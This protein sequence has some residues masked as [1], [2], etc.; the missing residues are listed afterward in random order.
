MSGLVLLRHDDARSLLAAAGEFL[1]AREAEHNLI[2]GLCSRLELDPAPYGETPYLV[3]VGRGG[4]IAAVALRTPPYKLVL[5]RIDRPA[6]VDLV[7]DDAAAVFPALPGVSGPSAAT[8]RFADCWRRLR[9]VEPRPG[10]AQRILRAERVV[11]PRPVPGVMRRAEAGDRPLL[12]DWL[13]A[14]TT[15]A[16]PGAPAGDAAAMA[17][18]RLAGMAGAGLF[19]WEDEGRPVALAGC[20]GRTPNG[21]RVGPVYTPPEL[22]GRGYA[23]A[24]T[25]ALTQTLLDGGRRFCFLFTDLANP[26][27]N[28]LYERI[29]YER[30]ADVDEYRF[31]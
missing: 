16:V 3:S 31:T 25:A 1:V 9:G 17:D 21:I 14:F 10:M 19:L 11:P 30:V 22:R 26:T 15:E 27:S 12:L 23:S 6:A 7:A 2:L 5:S 13:A 4:E 29:G 24:L 8:R 20:A 28:R 18:E